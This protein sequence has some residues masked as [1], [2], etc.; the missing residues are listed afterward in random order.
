MSLLV[1]GGI[2]TLS[3][4]TIDGDKDWNGCKITN[5]GAPTTADDVLRR[6]ASLEDMPDMALNK[7]MVGQGAGVGP[8]ESDAVGFW[9][10]IQAITLA[11]PASDITFSGIPSSYKHLRVVAEFIPDNNGHLRMQ[12]NDDT[13]NRYDFYRLNLASSYYFGGFSSQAYVEAVNMLGSPRP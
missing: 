7:I 5:L 3:Q 2:T 8:I 11:S 6:R 13:G 1:R 12:F 10:T 9:T 4:L